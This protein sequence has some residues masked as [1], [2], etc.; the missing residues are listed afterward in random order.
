L[1][2]TVA[3]QQFVLHAPDE[4]SLEVLHTEPALLGAEHT[5]PEST[6]L[7]H[8]MQSPV[9]EH[10]VHVLPTVLLQQLYGEDAPSPQL[11]L[12]HRESSPPKNV[13]LHPSP[14]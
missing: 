6:P 14:A 7:E 13:S 1:P 9:L 10:F 4:H 3:A 5:P 11:L 2:S 12:A 8:A